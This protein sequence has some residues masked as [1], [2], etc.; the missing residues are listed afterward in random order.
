MQQTLDDRIKDS[1]NLL[2][3]LFNKD[4]EAKSHIEEVIATNLKDDGVNDAIEAVE[5]LYNE[6]I[7]DAI[8]RILSVPTKTI[9]I[10]K[11]GEYTNEEFF[12]FFILKYRKVFLKLKQL[13]ETG[14]S[15]LIRIT[16]N[17]SGNIINYTMQRVDNTYLEFRVSHENQIGIINY[18]IT[19]LSNHI[20]K[21][22]SLN[23][24]DLV[25]FNNDFLAL[26]ESTN[27]LKNAIEKRLEELKDEYH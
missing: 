3:E 8:S 18:L 27:S 14:Y 26:I 5:L 16:E 20:E 6:D 1:L 17:I 22:D 9:N 13:E 11:N 24:L 21:S 4:P 25:D 7:G 2:E 15:T 23:S 19:V 12:L 10:I